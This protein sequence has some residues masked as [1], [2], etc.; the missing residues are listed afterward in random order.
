VIDEFVYQFQEFALFTAKS[1]DLS[2]QDI[3][4][5]KEHKVWNVVATLKYLQAWREMDGW[6]YGC[7]DGW[8]Y[9]WLLRK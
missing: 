3:A 8:M 4:L 7:M 9:G 1:K 2:V 6:M 5:L